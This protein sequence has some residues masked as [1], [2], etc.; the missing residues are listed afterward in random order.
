M[1]DSFNEREKGFEAKFKLDTEQA[2]KAEARRNR[3]LG[4]WLA[5]K[6][7][8]PSD[9]KEAY[10]KAVVLADMDEPGI[11]DVVR[12]VMSDISERGV[13]VS[14]ADIRAKIAELDAVA[15]EQIANE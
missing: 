13:D 5:D 4:E 1:S 6:F 15:A 12:K 14:E 10:A 11:D 2:F 3:L 9:E 8:M 7:G